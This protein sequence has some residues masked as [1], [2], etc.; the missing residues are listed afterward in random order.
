MF[1]DVTH[2]IYLH[3]A[4]ASFQQKRFVKSGLGHELK[5]FDIVLIIYMVQSFLTQVRLT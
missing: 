5:I 4:K 3:F 2:H 1:S